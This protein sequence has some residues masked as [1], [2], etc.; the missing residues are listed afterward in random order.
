MGSNDR[1]TGRVERRGQ[2]EGSNDGVNR[3]GRTTG[4]T[5]RVERRGRPEGSNDGVDRKGR[6][7]GSNDRSTGRV[8]RRGEEKR[9]YGRAVAREGG[10]ERG[11][12]ERGEQK[13]LGASGGERERGGE[14]KGNG[15]GGVHWLDVYGPGG[16]KR[17]VRQVLLP[18]VTMSRT[19]KGRKKR[20]RKSCHSIYEREELASYISI[21]KPFL[22]SHT[23][24]SGSVQ[25]SASRP[26]VLRRGAV[27][28]RC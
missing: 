15:S 6:K 18:I 16:R 20:R 23:S 7:T 19:T 21:A 22:R 4:S 9:C 8:E 26:T 11:R 25:L 24:A 12:S 1:S 17:L 3:K 27:P 2:P 13:V 5:G 10:N 14:Q 28:V